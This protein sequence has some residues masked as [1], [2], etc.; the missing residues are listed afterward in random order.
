MALEDGGHQGPLDAPPIDDAMLW[1]DEDH[2]RDLHAGDL[3]NPMLTALQRA[4]YQ[5]R[6]LAREN[7][8]T[9]QLDAMFTAYLIAKVKTSN[10]AKSNW[11]HD[12]K[13]TC[14]CAGKNQGMRDVV[15]VDYESRLSPFD[16][17]TTRSKYLTLLGCGPQH[18]V[19]SRSASVLVIRGAIRYDLLKWGSLE[20]QPPSLGQRSLCGFW[21]YTTSFGNSAGCALSHLLRVS[22]SF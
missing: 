5:A 8:W 18:A 6:V 14:S 11:N 12:F 17:Q 10:W 3:A 4:A 1:E 15:L 16:Y 19:R 13:P 22:M 20:G 21:S 7:A 2:N 9:Q